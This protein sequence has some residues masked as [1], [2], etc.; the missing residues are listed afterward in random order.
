MG[1][2]VTW[3]LL[4]FRRDVIKV[5]TGENVVGMEKIEKIKKPFVKEVVKGCIYNYLLSS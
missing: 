3:L 2:L 4:L 5:S 1:K